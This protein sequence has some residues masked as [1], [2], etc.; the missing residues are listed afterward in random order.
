M[1]ES[2][3]SSPNHITINVCVDD[4]TQKDN[5]FSQSSSKSLKK[6]STLHHLTILRIC[7]IL[8][9]ILHYFFNILKMNSM[10][11][12]DTGYYL[13]SESLKL[14]KIRMT[15]WLS[16][17]SHPRYFHYCEITTSQKDVCL[18]VIEMVKIKNAE[19]YFQKIRF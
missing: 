11:L 15:T 2:N 6:T 9:N 13:L 8:L 17:D 7:F 1:T 12:V 14:H 3:C 19:F 4:I 16:A 10:A 18:T 5:T